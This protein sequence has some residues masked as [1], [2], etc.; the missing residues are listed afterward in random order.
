M[1]SDLSRYES[2]SER[3]FEFVGSKG[4]GRFQERNGYDE[5]TFQRSKI[6]NTFRMLKPHKNVVQ[7]YG[8]CVTPKLCIVM[9]HLAGSLV[10]CTFTMN[11]LRSSDKK[12]TSNKDNHSCEEGTRACAGNLCRDGVPCKP[13]DS[14]Q[15][16]ER[17]KYLGA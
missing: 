14:S 16:L 1:G 4:V 8:V 12:N 10:D 9:E 7:A 13:K 2:G 17:K 5:V 15:R 11:A 3:V 6:T